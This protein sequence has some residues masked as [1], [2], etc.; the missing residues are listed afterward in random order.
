L[1]LAFFDVDGTL[2]VE[3]DPYMYLHR[4]LGTEAQGFANLNAFLAG[5]FDYDT[6]AQ[7]DAGL[8]AGLETARI[9]A[10]C[11]AIPY[12]PEARALAERL[13]AAGVSIVLIS[14]G[15]DRHVRQVARD[16]GVS[17]WVCNELLAENGRLTG[18]M[19]VRVYWSHKGTHVRDYMARHGIA[20]SECLAVGDSAG[21][22]SM[23]AEVQHRIAVN[24]SDESVRTAA[25]RVLGEAGLEAWLAERGIVGQAGKQADKGTR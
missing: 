12:I 23:F 4:Q 22:L 14:T 1:R 18:R 24:P 6:F 10:L 21:D 11:A 7:R 3:R 9:D 15:I 19:H 5:E 16:L 13:R 20:G 25:D 8:W 2:K 17:D